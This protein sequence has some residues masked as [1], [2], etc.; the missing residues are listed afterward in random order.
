MAYA[1]KLLDEH[2]QSLHQRTVQ[3]EQ[4]MKHQI[5]HKAPVLPGRTWPCLQQQHQQQHNV[6]TPVILNV[7]PI[8]LYAAKGPLQHQPIMPGEALLPLHCA[9]NTM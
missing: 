4:P 9:I 5:V 1:Q 7:T 6:F 2:K 3:K 8:I